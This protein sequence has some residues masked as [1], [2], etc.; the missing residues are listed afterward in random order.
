MLNESL[1]PDEPLR[2]S[3][4]PVSHG[5][6]T[7]RNARSYHVGCSSRTTPLAPV[8]SPAT[9]LGF[10]PSAGAGSDSSSGFVDG[11]S[12]GARRSQPPAAATA[13]EVASP[14]AARRRG[15][16]CGGRRGRRQNDCGNCCAPRRSA[17]VL[18]PSAT[19]N[20]QAHR[21]DLSDVHFRRCSAS[22]E[23]SCQS[24]FR[25]SGGPAADGPQPGDGVLARNLLPLNA[26]IRLRMQCKLRVPLLASR[27]N[28]AGSDQALLA[29]NNS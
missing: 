25:R 7:S 19:S 24:S 5:A 6:G 12:S 4:M 1:V 26:R 22:C 9:L 15:R 21:C 28:R 11:G 20:V 13:I 23:I 10:S 16:S 18:R 29:I 3:S 27:P 17:H 2:P 8:A 14:A